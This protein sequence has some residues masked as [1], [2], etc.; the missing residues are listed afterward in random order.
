MRFG[1][2]MIKKGEWKKIFISTV[3][4]S[5]IHIFMQYIAKYIVE[6]EDIDKDNPYLERNARYSHN[7]KTVADDR[8]RTKCSIYEE[9]IK[10]RLDSL[11][12]FIGLILLF[13][14]GIVICILIYLDDPGP[15]IFKQKR[16]G[17]Y[18]RFF[19]LHKFR[20]M[21]TSAPHD[22][23]THQLDDPEKYITR[24][25]KVLRKYSLDE[26]PQIWDI[27]RGKMSI[28]GPRP[29]LYNQDDLIA[30]RDRYGANDIMPGLTGWAQ[31]NGR[32]ELKIIDKARLDGEYVHYLKQGGIKALFFD[33]RCFT[34]TIISV[35]K[36]EGVIEGGTGGF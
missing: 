16:V 3:I 36:S 34:E 35:F 12:A 14:L 1:K 20:T 6:A 15:I 25:G 27:F 32:D 23:P 30:E 13:P 10:P 9:K 31:I 28:I 19:Y 33:I 7:K 22:K 11:L 8:F 29:A 21:K 18:K 26:L 2:S 4:F 5:S 24:I 17:K